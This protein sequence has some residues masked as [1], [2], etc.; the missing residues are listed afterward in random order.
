MTTLAPVPFGWTSSMLSSRPA[1]DDPFVRLW[2]EVDRLFSQVFRTDF[3]DWPERRT[4]TLPIEIV[5]TPDAFEIVAELPGVDPK[6]VTIELRGDLLT[7]KGE[8]KAGREESG[9]TWHVSERR[10]GSFARSLRLP[11][12]VDT[13]Q[14]EAQYKNG[15]LQVK[16]LKP[17]AMR[18]EVK[19]IEVKAAA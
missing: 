3:L 14:V 8:K 4:Y 11:F 7:I 12:S 2:N 6:D 9:A 16:L 13:E 19:R 18:Q 17:A 1:N 5:E 10:F 15:V